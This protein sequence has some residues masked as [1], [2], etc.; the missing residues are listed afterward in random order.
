MTDFV[1]DIAEIVSLSG[2][3]VFGKTRL[4]KTVYFLES[5]GL[6]YGFKFNYHYYGPYSEEL[7][8][9]VEDAHSLGTIKMDWRVSQTAIPY[10]AY[11][12]L[13]DSEIREPRSD[14]TLQRKAL[15]RSPPS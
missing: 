8:T 10:A 7:A 9:S 13:G 12:S 15:T 2:G 6:G 5:S 1:Q 14:E 11:E 4:Q 3:R